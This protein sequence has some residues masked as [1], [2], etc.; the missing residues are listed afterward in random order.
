MAPLHDLL[1]AR[2]LMA[3]KNHRAHLAAVRLVHT[4]ITAKDSLGF[5]MDVNPVNME[6]IS[7]IPLLIN[8]SHAASFRLPMWV[9]QVLLLAAQPSIVKK[10]APWGDIGPVNATTRTALRARRANTKICRSN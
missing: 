9:A 5:L 6:M 7:D 10:N 2:E 8:V 3:T 4:V 1:V